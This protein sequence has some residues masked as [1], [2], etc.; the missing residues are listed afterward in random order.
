[1]RCGLDGPPPWL[2]RPSAP[3]GAPQ[4]LTEGFSEVESRVSVRLRVATQPAVEIA[5]APASAG[6]QTYRA[7]LLYASRGRSPWPNRGRLL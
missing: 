4:E 7:K 3:D 1:M 6:E 2:S 5:V